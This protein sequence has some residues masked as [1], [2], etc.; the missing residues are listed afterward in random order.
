MDPALDVRQVR[1]CLPL[2]QWSWIAACAKPDLFSWR[3]RRSPHT[4]LSLAVTTV[5]ALATA[6]F[7]F[8][9]RKMTLACTMSARK[10]CIVKA[11]VNTKRAHQAWLLTHRS[12][13]CCIF[14]P[15]SPQ[16]PAVHHCAR[17]TASMLQIEDRRSMRSLGNEALDASWKESSPSIQPEL[18]AVGAIRV[19]GSSITAESEE[20]RRTLA[21]RGERWE[22]SV[23]SDG[24]DVEGHGEEASTASG[25]TITEGGWESGQGFE[26][27]E[28]EL[29]LGT[30]GGET[31]A[32]AMN[33]GGSASPPMRKKSSLQRV[34]E[35]ARCDREREWT[36]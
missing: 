19:Q 35:S 17:R 15:I 31:G 16:I 7:H 4:L 8:D 28:A 33:E 10:T 9:D 25:T 1:L 27:E 24:L 26:V 13:I 5:P 18:G 36:G 20:H 6:R 30:I 12:R 22:G 21:S 29:D 23:R 34:L 3:S 2:A 14:S 11:D 32:G